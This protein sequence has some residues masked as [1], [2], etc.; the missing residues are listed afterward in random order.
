LIID[1]DATR[2]EKQSLQAQIDELQGEL[3]AVMGL[4]AQTIVS[5]QSQIDSLRVQEGKFQP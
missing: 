3:R 1:L 4:W 5:L 2:K